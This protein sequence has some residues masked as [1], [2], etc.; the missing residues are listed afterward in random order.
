MKGSESAN[1]IQFS[2]DR[3]HW[4]ALGDMKTDIQNP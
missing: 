4:W 2:H 3:T 1:R